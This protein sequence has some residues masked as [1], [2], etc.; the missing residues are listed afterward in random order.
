MGW[1][2]LA[3]KK[4]CAVKLQIYVLR[5][6][7]TRVN[8]IDRLASRGHGCGGEL[9]SCCTSAGLDPGRVGDVNASFISL[10]RRDIKKVKQQGTADKAEA[11]PPP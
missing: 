10:L 2:P 11:A 6:F 4:I 5:G 1:N 9:I 3:Q 7:K 8:L